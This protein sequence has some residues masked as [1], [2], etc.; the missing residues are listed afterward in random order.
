VFGFGRRFIIC[1]RLLLI[2][3]LVVLHLHL[4]LLRT[5]HPGMSSIVISGVIL[6]T[7]L[8]TTTR[9]DTLRLGGSRF[10]GGSSFPFRRHDF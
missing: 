3:L 1:R 4:L 2:L 9:F 7:I 10:N 5:T 6:V 8:I